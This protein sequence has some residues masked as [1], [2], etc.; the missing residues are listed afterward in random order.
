M[1]KHSYNAVRLFVNQIAISIFGLV[2]A[3]AC[4]KVE[5]STL[6]IVTSVGAIIFYLFLTYAAMW[7]VGS[8]DK[9]GIDN[10]TKKES[11]LAGLFVALL[12]N[13]LNLLLAIV[14][15]AC[16]FAAEGGALYAAGALAKV[17][18]LFIEG[19]YTGLLS[20]D[21]GGMPLNN[22]WLSYF[23]ITVPSLLT[24]AL[25]YWCG[26]KGYHFSKILI[27]ENPE[28]AEIKR[29]KKNARNNKE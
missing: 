24:S 23:V 17:I 7:E 16:S 14:I 8:K 2:L 5:N 20:L 25:A 28:D 9:Y 27:P 29:E 22:Y 1:Q 12:S 10:G 15:L 18:A 6:K 13:S 19:M 26:T 4:G 21:F 3:I 11:P